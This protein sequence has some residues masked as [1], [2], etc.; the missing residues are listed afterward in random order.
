M[1]LCVC[2]TL[3]RRRRR[4]KKMMSDVPCP[5]KKKENPIKSVVV[6]CPS[7]F[8]FFLFFAVKEFVA[9]A[10]ELTERLNKIDASPCTYTHIVF[11]FFITFAREGRRKERK[12]RTR[13]EG[14]AVADSI[15]EEGDTWSIVRSCGVAHK[16]KENQSTTNTRRR[17]RTGG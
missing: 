10:T 14:G 8:P 17:R 6:R 16:K 9:G 4:R 3:E 7:Y 5:P 12:R 15:L 1:T 13:Y 2:V 11:F